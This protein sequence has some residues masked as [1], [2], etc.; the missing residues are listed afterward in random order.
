MGYRVL[1]RRGGVATGSS[2]FLGFFNHILHGQ[3]THTPLEAAT[4]ERA[5]L[6][7]TNAALRKL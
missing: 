6:P 4:N 1:A 7:P 3:R 5:Q 2:S